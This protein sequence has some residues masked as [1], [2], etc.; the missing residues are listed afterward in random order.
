LSSRVF[1]HAYFARPDEDTLSALEGWNET[2]ELYCRRDL[3]AELDDA[4]RQLAAHMTP[5]TFER[6]RALK[7]QEQT[8]AERNAK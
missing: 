1:G 8:A 5:E 4:Q 6:F 2:Y 7:M 3:Q